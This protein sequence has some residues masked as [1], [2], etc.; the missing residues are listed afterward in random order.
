[1]NRSCNINFDK[2][3]DM[4]IVNGDTIDLLKKLLESDP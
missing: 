1:M 3:L 4:K 2:E